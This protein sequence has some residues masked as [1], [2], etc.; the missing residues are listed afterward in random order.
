MA[1][2]LLVEPRADLADPGRGSR[3]EPDRARLG[4]PAPLLA[5]EADGPAGPLPASQTGLCAV[6]PR[7][8]GHRLRPD[9]DG[10]PGTLLRVWEQSGLSGDLAVTLPHGLKATQATPVNLRGEPAGKPLAIVGGTF[11]FRL[12]AFAPASFVLS[13]Q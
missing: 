5:A 7:R 11:E 6:A 10:N 8:V 4:G 13:S 1:G 2:R 9:P 12:P 3:Q